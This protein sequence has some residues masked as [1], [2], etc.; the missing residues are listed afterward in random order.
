MHREL[1]FS[2]RTFLGASA[3]AAATVALRTVGAGRPRERAPG[4]AGEARHPAVHRPRPDPAARQLRHRHEP[5]QPVLRAAASRRLPGRVRGARLVRLQ[6]RGVRR[7]HAGRER[8]DHDAGDPRAPRRVRSD[9]GRHAPG[10]QHAQD[11]PRVRDRALPDPRHGV[12]RDREPADGRHERAGRD[13]RRPQRRGLQG[14]RG[15]VQRVGRDL[16]RGGPQAVP[17]QP[18]GRVPLRHR[19]AER[20]RLRRLD[21]GDRPAVRPPGDGHLLGVR[22]E[23]PVPR[24]SSRSTTCRRSRTGTRS[25][26]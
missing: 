25:G 8:G 15:R 6:D 10:P 26:T 13:R 19:P 2:R 21:R 11:E 7:V 12:H 5:G 14:G 23:E 9:R 4:A 22:G 1:T 20:P 16:R 24:A 17:A 3:G 18:H